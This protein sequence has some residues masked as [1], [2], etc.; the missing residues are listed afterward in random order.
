MTSTEAVNIYLKGGMKSIKLHY[1]IVYPP[2]TNIR[3]WGEKTA[4]RGLASN[5]IGRPSFFKNDERKELQRYPRTPL[6]TR[7][8]VV[9][10]KKKCQCH[11]A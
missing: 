1:G 3:W 8:W 2:Q 10:G 6:S 11:I 7:H 4:T 9:P 5:C